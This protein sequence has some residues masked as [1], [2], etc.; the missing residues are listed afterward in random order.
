MQQS[1]RRLTGP[2]ARR[3]AL[4][5]ALAALLAC[6]GLV[7]VGAHANLVRAIPAA[8][9]T[10]DTPPQ[11]VAAEFSERL[12]PGFSRIDVL[13]AS[14]ASVADGPSQVD[15]SNRSAMLVRVPP[16]ADGTY[17]VAWR[18]LSVVDGHLIRGSYVFSVGEPIDADVASA[19]ESALVLSP[20]EPVLRAVLLIG[21]MLVLGTAVHV[22]LIFAPAARA[23]GISQAGSRYVELAWVGLG[24][25]A[26][27]HV[28]L[29]LTQ[30]VGLAGDAEAGLVSAVGSCARPGSVGPAVDRSSR[31]PR[32]PG[33]GAHARRQPGA[34]SVGMA[35]GRSPVCGLCSSPFRWAATR[36]RCSNPPSRQPAPMCCICL[37]PPCGP[38][39]WRRCCCRWCMPAAHTTV[40]RA[41]AC[42][43]RCWRDSRR[44]PRSRLAP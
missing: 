33:A 20:A 6:L 13:D 11:V 28:G 17:V 1:L 38:A 5:T 24:L 26:G 23:V 4:A 37:R 41:A 34:S 21:A 35:A 7:P 25:A 9:S 12:E 19:P 22:P 39:A 2:P 31:R 18:T 14:G 15:P 10:V 44:L 40:S 42:S 36:R 16:L 43:R 29:L 32:R 27:A 3:W 30:A 8:G